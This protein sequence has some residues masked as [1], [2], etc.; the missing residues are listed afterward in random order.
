MSTPGPLAEYLRARRQQVDPRAAGLAGDDANRRVDGL[1]REEVAM[2]AGISA[3]Y[4]LRL[5]QGRLLNPSARVL[6]GLVRALRLSESE[7]RHL[8]SLAFPESR[9]STERVDEISDSVRTLAESLGAYPI[10]INN[11]CLDVLWIN[12]LSR[13]IA[14]GIRVGDNLVRLVFESTPPDH[15][16]WRASTERVVAH[17]RASA[18]FSKDS[19]DIAEL[20]SEMSEKSDRFVELWERHDVMSAS[21][22]PMA[23]Y[24]AD[25]GHMEFRYQAF[26]LP[27]TGGQMLGIFSPA[28]A[29][30]SA[31]ALQQLAAMVTLDAEF[32]SADWSLPRDA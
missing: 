10:H 28:P 13:A 7:A 25:V 11:R 15:A 16:Y 32:E 2:L 23:F 30:Q 5:E 17:L 3:D 22:F 31:L 29:S 14:P 8:Y 9:Q 18:D 1:R 20:V 19:A 12:G 4:Y 21:G 6:E 27:K 26:T 24:R